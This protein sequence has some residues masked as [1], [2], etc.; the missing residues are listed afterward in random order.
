[1]HLIPLHAETETRKRDA[2]TSSD[3]ESFEESDTESG[4]SREKRETKKIAMQQLRRPSFLAAPGRHHYGSFYLRMGAV[5][6]YRVLIS[7]LASDFQSFFHCRFAQHSVS[8]A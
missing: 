8:V 4:S 5:G 1:M 7:P 2:E 3:L 6:E